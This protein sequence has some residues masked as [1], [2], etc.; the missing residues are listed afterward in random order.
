MPSTSTT[1]G[2]ARRP[3]QA[4][5][6]ARRS[7]EEDRRRRMWQYLLAMGV[8]TAS[9]PV[10]VW[11]FMTERYA[12]AWVAVALAALIPAFAVML[13]NAVDQRRAPGEAPR[14][15]TRGLGAPPTRPA[16]RPGGADTVLTGEVL[17]S[18]HTRSDADAP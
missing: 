10:A 5:T 9:F 8:R 15:P 4:V 2:K 18:R 11:A 13:A 6:A 17:S 12:I 1:T 7:V 16:P 14:S 3:A